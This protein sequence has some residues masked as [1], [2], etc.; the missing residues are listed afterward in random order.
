M[1]QSAFLVDLFPAKINQL[2]D[3]QPMTIGNQNQRSVA[4]AVPSDALCRDPEPLY[5]I[6]RQVFPTSQ[7]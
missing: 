5:F 4:K 7:G 2:R 3:A 1:Q 6:W